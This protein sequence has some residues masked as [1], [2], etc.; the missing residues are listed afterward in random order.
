VNDTDPGDKKCKLNNAT[1]ASA[2]YYYA[3]DTVYSSASIRNQLLALAEGDRL[4]FQQRGAESIRYHIFKVT[5]PP[6]AAIG[7]VKVPI[8]SE[9]AGSDL[10]NNAQ[11]LIGFHYT[12]P[13]IQRIASN[14]ALAYGSSL[15]VSFPTDRIPTAIRGI[16][17]DAS[18]VIGSLADY[19]KGSKIV[20]QI[21]KFTDDAIRVNWYYSN[22]PVASCVLAD[23][24]IVI[25]YWCDD[26]TTIKFQ[27][28]NGSTYALIGTPV[29]VTT[30]SQTAPAH[31]KVSAIPTTNNF[32]I[33]WSATTANK[34]GK[35]AIYD[36]TGTK[37]NTMETII[38][39]VAPA[40]DWAVGDT[41]TGQSSGVTSTVV[42]KVASLYY[43]VKNR[44]GNYMLNEIIGVTGVPAKLADQGAANPIISSDG[45]YSV[46]SDYNGVCS[47]SDGNIV[48]CWQ[49]VTVTSSVKYCVL[50]KAGELVEAATAVQTLAG[51]GDGVDVCT[52][53]NNFWAL[54]WADVNDG[55]FAV[56]DSSTNPSTLKQAKTTYN[57]NIFGGSSL[58]K[59]RALP[60]KAFV[61]FH[62]DEVTG[63][64]M[65][66][67]WK[68]VSD[69][70]W[71]NIEYIQPFLSV[72]ANTFGA[73]IS[74]YPSERI[75]VTTLPLTARNGSAI[76]SPVFFE[77]EEMY[78]VKGPTEG[79][80]PVPY[81]S[82]LTL[83]YSASGCL[84]LPNKR[85]LMYWSDASDLAKGKFVVL[86]QSHF[87]VVEAAGSVTLYNYTGLTQDVRLQ[88]E[89]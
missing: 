88:V 74:S 33:V 31:F 34:Q 45:T 12:R 76:F 53:T 15:A 86:Q 11:V 78:K 52:L 8:I 43:V 10:Q 69:T 51:T 84:C 54:I 30:D 24:T 32:V 42:F 17:K 60:N 64:D 83:N 62:H 67:R 73:A 21:T 25:A 47:L 35:W 1:Q 71:V 56:Y 70:S 22:N 59:I 49:D 63:I 37:Q 66:S 5:A 82:S 13:G 44:S 46:T 38:L 14:A 9:S 26:N 57:L 55:V 16:W 68:Y 27:L 39:N 75:V 58:S 65:L 4:Y 81:G 79:R 18:G 41:I 80:M 29:T 19:P 77:E 3:D 20:Q 40:T 85:V 2:T 48:I 89:F 36:N 61:I 87:K 7:Y 50:T 6:I 72:A 28:I 23:G